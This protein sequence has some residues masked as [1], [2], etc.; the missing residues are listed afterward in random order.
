MLLSAAATAAA[1][2]DLVPPYAAVEYSAAEA[3]SLHGASEPFSKFD[4]I[5]L[6][7]VQAGDAT[8]WLRSTVTQLT[9]L[10]G[11]AHIGSQ[12]LT[13]QQANSSVDLIQIWSWHDTNGNG[14]ADEGDST[15]QWTKLIELTPSLSGGDGSGGCRRSPSSCDPTQESTTVGDLG[16][17]A[18]AARSR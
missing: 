18:H 1:H 11:Y 16:K 13:Q 6:H 8:Y 9:T 10:R 15:V 7:D 2:L 3:E 14:K 12:G 4:P 5:L 17:G